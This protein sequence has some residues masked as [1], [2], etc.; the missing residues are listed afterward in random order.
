MDCRMPDDETMQRM[1]EEYDRA[2]RRSGAAA[3]ALSL[4]E[5]AAKERA[6][7]SPGCGLLLLYFAFALGYNFAGIAR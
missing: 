4:K 1:A 5:S 7:S 6:L 2:L 3:G